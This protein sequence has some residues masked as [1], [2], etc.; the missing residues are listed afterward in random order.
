V[1]F[2]YYTAEFNDIAVVAGIKYW[3]RLS[4]YTWIGNSPYSNELLLIDNLPPAP[5][6]AVTNDQPHQFT[7]T[8]TATNDDIV[9]IKIERAPDNSG[10]PG[11][12]IQIAEPTTYCGLIPTNYTDIGIPTGQTYWYRVRAVNAV[13]DS[14]YSNPASATAAGN[15]PAL[16]A[17]AR[18]PQILSI[19]PINGGMLIQWSTTGGST[20]IVQASGNFDSG[21]TNLSPESVAGGTG[22]TTMNYFDAGALTNAPMR[23]YRIQSSR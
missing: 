19:T 13:G 10:V 17:V 9:S 1:P 20:D 23:F 14:P 18:P 8:W 21:Y 12:W 22:A 16:S 3:Y 15:I 2:S 6:L 5:T 11:T 7:L 4:A